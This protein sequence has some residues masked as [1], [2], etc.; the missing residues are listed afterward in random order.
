MSPLRRVRSLQKFA[1][2]HSSVYNHFNLERHFYSRSNFK[3][4]RDVA[5]R[6]WRELIAAA[7]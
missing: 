7:A 4:N 2:L 6:E 5:L 1:S 3:K